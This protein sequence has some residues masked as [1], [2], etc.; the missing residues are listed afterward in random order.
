MGGMCSMQ[1]RGDEKMHTEFW[2]VPGSD[3]TTYEKRKW[4]NNIKINPK[5]IE[6]KGVD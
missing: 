5:E 4:E 3:E 6:C 1:E 2:S